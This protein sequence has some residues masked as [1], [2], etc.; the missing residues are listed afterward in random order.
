VPIHVAGE[1]ELSA[2]TRQELNKDYCKLYHTPRYTSAFPDRTEFIQQQRGAKPTAQKG[3]Q[4]E[5]KQS[6]AEEEVM[7]SWMF[8]PPEVILG[9][10][11]QEW[12]M[13]RFVEPLEALAVTLLDAGQL[14]KLNQVL[15]LVL[16]RMWC[17]EGL[18]R[19]VFVSKLDVPALIQVLDS[20][21]RPDE[22][23][24]KAKELLRKGNIDISLP[25]L[26][27][28][29]AVEPSCRCSD[30]AAKKHYKQADHRDRLQPGVFP[31]WPPGR[32]YVLDHQRLVVRETESLYNCHKPWCPLKDRCGSTKLSYT[33]TAP[34][35]AE[36][37]ETPPEEVQPRVEEAE[38][39]EGGGWLEQE[40]YQGY[41]Q[42]LESLQN[43]PQDALPLTD[44]LTTYTHCLD[45]LLPVKLTQG[46]EKDRSVTFRLPGVTQEGDEQRRSSEE[47]PP[48]I[49]LSECLHPTGNRIQD[50]LGLRYKSIAHR[51]YA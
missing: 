12:P 5:A 44:D 24:L 46:D 34:Q 30:S 50:K 41:I 13:G 29:P 6:S 19:C 39:A 36:G 15:G 27:C 28:P 8:K 42:R 33:Y 26:R 43:R 25:P 51:R 38:R 18:E 3:E 17:Q 22:L 48:L 9:D 40:Q 1:Y 49:P 47:L 2:R 16:Q 11:V 20:D 45:H 37:S 10:L 14:V 23:V 21:L 31:C 35:A 7:T 32:S 4:T